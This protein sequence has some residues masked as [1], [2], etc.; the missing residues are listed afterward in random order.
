[1]SFVH[2]S[3]SIDAEIHVCSGSRGFICRVSHYIVGVV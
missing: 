3:R 2:F 1:M